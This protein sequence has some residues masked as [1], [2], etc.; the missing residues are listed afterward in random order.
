T[1]LNVAVDNASHWITG[2]AKPAGVLYVH[3]HNPI[4]KIEEELDEATLEME[5]LRK[6]RMKGLL[7][8]DIESLVLMDEELQESGKSKII[9]VQ[10]KK[11][12]S[13]YQRN[14]RVVIP[15]EMD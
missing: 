10:L 15:F 12:G 9:P 4:L 13:V 14:S 8:E 2:E 1:Y 3:V 11:D 6:F 7:A 5:R